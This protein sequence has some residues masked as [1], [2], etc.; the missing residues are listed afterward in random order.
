MATRALKWFLHG[1]L[2]LLAVV[3]LLA[4]SGL[5]YGELGPGTSA[6]RCRPARWRVPRSLSRR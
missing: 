5:G 4:G 1:L 2:A 6:Q 3:A